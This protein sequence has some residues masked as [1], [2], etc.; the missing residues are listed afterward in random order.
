MKSYKPEG[1]YP[2]ILIPFDSE[3]NLNE[4]EL[5]N[6][7]DWLI[8][9][10]VHGLFP[11]GSVGEFIHYSFEEKVRIIK[12][13]I[14]QARGRVPV[15]PGATDSCASNCIKLI[16]E[17]R[18]LGCSAT[19]VAPPYYLPISQ[20]QIE[21]HYEQIL[22]ETPGF[23]LII[24]NI[25]AFST[26]IDFDVL[27]RL[28]RNQFVVGMKDS[29]G[30]MVDFMHFMDKAKIAGSDLHMMTGREE[31]LIAALAV[32]AK[33]MMT[34]TAA[35]IP[36]IMTNIFKTWNDGDSKM[37]LELQFEILQLIRAMYAL[38]L[39]LGFKAALVARGFNMGESKRPLSAAEQYNYH[40]VLS[41]IDIV[42]NKLG[43][44]KIQ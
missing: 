21:E 20:E 25:P 5:R 10:G 6:I 28:C 35:I 30:S 8:D 19:V 27:K 7:I 29:S 42:L 24:Y 4:E 44:N 13:V 36:E 22:K 37:A 11:L 3:G 17:A 14:E 23:P 18:S 9:E 41:R 15:I 26:S 34:A 32:G 31:M 2:A 33:G 38:P 40:K 43:I 39:P 16:R 1:I 12:V